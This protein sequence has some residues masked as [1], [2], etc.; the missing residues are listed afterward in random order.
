MENLQKI[1]DEIRAE[2]DLKNA[3][4]DKT[5]IAMREAIRFC[6]NSIRSLHRGEFDE[7]AKLLD[8]ARIRIR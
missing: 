7:A 6:A 3:V 1:A 8:E 5:L 2:M 4:R